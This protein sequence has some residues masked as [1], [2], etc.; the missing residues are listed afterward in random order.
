MLVL[1]RKFDEQ[2][3]IG[4][5]I[6]ITVVKIQGDKVRIGI[7]EAEVAKVSSLLSGRQTL[8]DYVGLQSDTSQFNADLRAATSGRNAAKIRQQNRRE[9]GQLRFADDGDL[10]GDELTLNTTENASD[11][12][13][14]AVY[15]A[16]GWGQRKLYNT[17]TSLGVNPREALDFALNPL[18]MSMRPTRDIVS[19][20]ESPR[21]S[22]I[23]S[24]VN[25]AVAPSSDQMGEV[26]RELK[27]TNQELKKISGN[28][29]P[30]PS[31]QIKRNESP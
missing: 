5:D 12:F 2:I 23:I 30:K 21:Y 3:R 4:D 20:Y 27:E 13:G 19:D 15:Q 6:K 26:V 16:I 8:R 24:N 25:R 22:E 11:T 18:D 28:T 14:G 1:S 9:Q 31:R 7:G 10:I 17:A 29:K